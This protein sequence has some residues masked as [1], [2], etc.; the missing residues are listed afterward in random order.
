MNVLLIIMACLA[1]MAAGAAVAWLWWRG[2]WARR[3]SAW[4]TS[5]AQQEERQRTAQERLSEQQATLVQAEARQSAWLAQLDALRSERAQLLERAARLPELEAALQHSRGQQE[6]AQQLVAE[7]RAQCAQA[8][9][10]LQ[11]EVAQGEEKLAL[12]REA[13]EQLSVQFR[14]VANELLEEK[15]RRFVEQNRESL[16]AVLEPLRERLGEFT[17]KVES[18]YAQEAKERF[19]LQQEVLRL[20]EL[21]RKISDDA[22]NLTRALKGSN[23][24]QG[25][26]GEVV[27][28]SVLES[29]GLRRGQEYE[30]QTSFT[31][32]DGQRHQ[33]DVVVHLPEGRD[34]VIDSKVTLTAYS[35]YVE[36]EDDA[37]RQLAL[38]QHLDAVRAHVKGLSAKR[39]DTLYDLRSLD[40][41]LLFIP[42]EPAFMLA[43]T[44][45][46]EL[47]A[48]AYARNVLLVSPSTLLATLRTIANLWRQAQQ[49]HNAQE[50]A[51]QAGALYDKF[52]GFIGDLDDIGRHLTQT[53]QAFDGACNKLSSG[54]GN[55]VRQTERLRE[56][57]V[58]PGK[59]IPAGWKEKAGA[60]DADTPV[61]PEGHA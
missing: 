9:T 28:E 43:V 4:Q 3:E 2:Q 34:I 56:L 49:S 39:Y 51:R 16:G 27:L 48:D 37:A 7:L 1:G 50:I 59:S 47:F 38:R 5:L 15:S 35:R 46:R 10:R 21:N 33:P 42:V 57:G 32:E 44:E 36:A 26:W 41:V 22:V 60:D 23:K 18:S 61:L 19:S 54:R 53:R 52:V 31:R 45:D 40:F 20:A 12:L 25:N 6:A 8:E 58:K 29:S 11:A 13:R 17:R 30:V 24:Q 14:N 55:L